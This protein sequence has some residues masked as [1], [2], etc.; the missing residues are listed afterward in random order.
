VVAN[1]DDVGKVCAESGSSE[2]QSNVFDQLLHSLKFRLFL[3]AELDEALLLI[4]GIDALVEVLAQLGREA[5]GGAVV[6]AEQVK[7]VISAQCDVR[8]DGPDAR[9]LHQA[10]PT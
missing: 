7:A 2:H 10:R 9:N 6:F 3:T 1:S 4:G 5:G 8:V